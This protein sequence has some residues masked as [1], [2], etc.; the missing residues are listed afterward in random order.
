MPPRKIRVAAVQVDY[1]PSYLGRSFSYLHEPALLQEA[2]NGLAALVEFSGIALERALIKQIWVDNICRKLEAI[3]YFCAVHET[4]L[5]VFPE[6]SLP[7]EALPWCAQSARER[8]MVIV[9][10]SHT[11]LGDEES[12]RIYEQAGLGNLNLSPADPESD[13]RK[14]ICPIF[15][16]DSAPTVIEKNARSV[17]ESDMAGGRPAKT[18]EISIRGTKFRLA[19]LLCIDAL[20]VSQLAQLYSGKNT[21]E[22]LIVPSLSQSTAPFEHVLQL[23]LM[24]EVPSI[25]ANGAITGGSRV[26]ARSGTATTSWPAEKE[27]TEPLTREVEAVV[28]ADIDFD[29]QMEV[30]RTIKP[31]LG[32]RV[33]SLA[34]LLY[35]SHSDLCQTFSGLRKRCFAPRLDKLPS[36]ARDQLSMLCR[37]DPS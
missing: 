5:V 34:P 21:P 18:L 31:H 26:F 7:I 23:F 24:N 4:D 10:G 32:M 35:T 14:S 37:T 11:V 15:I 8:R 27:G 3:L 1:Q 9:G 25:Y 36:D 12:R 33:R 19:V 13:I 30:R 2:E 17:W 16:P 28:I 6:Y 22:L 29:E 20:D